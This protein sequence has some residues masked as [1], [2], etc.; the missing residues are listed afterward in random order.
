MFYKKQMPVKSENE[1]FVI[2]GNIFIYF[3]Y[4]A[5]YVRAGRKYRPESGHGGVFKPETRDKRPF[6]V[7]SDAI[8]LPIRRVIVAPRVSIGPGKCSAQFPRQRRRT[9][10][11]YRCVLFRSKRQRERRWCKLGRKGGGRE[12]NAGYIGRSC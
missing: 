2:Y 9:A 11:I 7:T 3:T 8:F 5:A 6:A 1:S 10:R 4:A 12:E